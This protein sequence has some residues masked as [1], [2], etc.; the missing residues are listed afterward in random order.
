MREVE[1]EHG[2]GK[3]AGGEERSHFGKKLDGEPVFEGGVLPGGVDRVEVEDGKQSTREIG[4]HHG[5]DCVAALDSEDRLYLVRQFRYAYGQELWE[6]PAGK[7]EK[8]E[9]PFDAARRELEEEVGLV[10][11]R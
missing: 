11:D 7:L 2:G 10:A 8:G 6:L 4:R 5:G 3:A 9:D 1:G